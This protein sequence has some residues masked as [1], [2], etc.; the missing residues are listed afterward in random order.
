MKIKGNKTGSLNI[1][2]N[3]SNNNCTKNYNVKVVINEST[4]EL[5]S[6]EMV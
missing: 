3:K 6:I 2:Y 5:L 4:G 1:K